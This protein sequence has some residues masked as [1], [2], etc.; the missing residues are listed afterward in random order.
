MFRA[1][2]PSRSFIDR[3]LHNDVGGDYVRV[4]EASLKRAGFVNRGRAACVVHEIYRLRATENSV[5][6]GEP[7]DRKLLLLDRFAGAHD[8]QNLVDGLMKKSAARTNDRFGAGQ[9]DL[10]SGAFAQ[11]GH[12]AGG[13]L[14]PRK[15][16]EGVD[17]VSRIAECDG[18]FGDGKTPKDREIVERTAI[19]GRAQVHGLHESVGDEKIIDRKIV[20]AGAPQARDAPGVEDFDVGGRHRYFHHLG[21]SVFGDHRRAFLEQHRAEDKDV[22]LLASAAEWPSARETIAVV[23][24]LNL[25]GG[26]HAAGDNCARNR[27]DQLA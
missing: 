13:N 8:T 4:A 5:H 23:G 22:G 26:S 25:P 14:G 15:I 11:Q 1:V 12:L 3:R 7:Q 19:D 17:S 2:H 18:S 6:R 24:S 27:G 9:I 16:L 10:Q 21:D 20:T